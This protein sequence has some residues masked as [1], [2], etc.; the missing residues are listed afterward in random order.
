MLEKHLPRMSL[1]FD[2]KRT[3]LRLT[4]AFSLVIRCKQRSDAVPINPIPGLVGTKAG[5][6]WHS[7]GEERLRVRKV[8]DIRLFGG[9]LTFASYLSLL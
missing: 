2:L 1:F 4:P 8:R 3:E 6:S 5:A 9:K 7:V